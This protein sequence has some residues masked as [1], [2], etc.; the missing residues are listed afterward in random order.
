MTAEETERK[1]YLLQAF[2]ALV[3]N[4]AWTQEVAPRIAKA[5]VEHNDG[6]KARGKTPEQRAEHV[7]AAHL[8]EE[9]ETFCA[10]RIESLHREITAFAKANRET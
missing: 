10:K 6:C 8:A 4:P 7:E 1:A 3:A 2:R 9:L 5:A